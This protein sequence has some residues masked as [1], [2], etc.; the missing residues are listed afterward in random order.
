MTE[1]KVNYSAEVT[2][3][4]VARYVA[5][6]TDET[7]VAVV[8]AVAKELGKNEASVRAKLVAEGVYVAVTRVGKKTARKSALVTSLAA[9][10]GLDEEVIGSVEKATGVALVAIIGAVGRIKY[11][12][13]GE[14]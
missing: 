12:A 6:G 9:S 4:L 13:E 1:V 11:E 10:L 3:D 5:E 14:G 8:K 7:R 2:K